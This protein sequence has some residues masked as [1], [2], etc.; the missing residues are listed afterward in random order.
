M[1]D[2]IPTKELRQKVQ[3]VALARFHLGCN[4]E[5]LLQEGAITQEQFDEIM[6]VTGA[7]M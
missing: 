6:T 1:T 5:I 3:R 2:Q 7:R 4:L